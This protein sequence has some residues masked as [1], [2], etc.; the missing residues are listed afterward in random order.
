MEAVMMALS[1]GHGP[2]LG[3]RGL[4]DCPAGYQADETGTCIS[5]EDAI[6]KVLNT[7]AVT[8]TPAASSS[9]NWLESLI[10]GVAKTGENILTQQN[11]A[12]GVYTQTSPTG[13]VTYVQPAG[14]SQNIFGASSTG[15]TGT[16]SGTLS[17][18][19][20]LILLAG[21]GLFLVFMLAKK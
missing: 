20:G 5:P 16:A 10:S 18:G 21:A 7:P 13:T 3:C 9:T 6:L 19:T 14:T 8:P 4:G 15:I 17:S 2:S 1:C 12:K 11:L